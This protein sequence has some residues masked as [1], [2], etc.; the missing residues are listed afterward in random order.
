[1]EI[2]QGLFIIHFEFKRYVK[3]CLC[4]AGMLHAHDAARKSEIKLNSTTL[5]D[6][7]QKMSCTE[8]YLQTLVTVTV[9]IHTSFKRDHIAYHQSIPEYLEALFQNG[10][11][12][13]CIRTLRNMGC[14]LCVSKPPS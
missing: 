5:E 7:E 3:S 8:T 6:S 4:K 9:C 11:R 1:M 12:V 2:F 14:S 10:A 13:I